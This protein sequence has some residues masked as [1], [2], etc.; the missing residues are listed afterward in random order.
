MIN[1]LA[2]RSIDNNTYY[3]LKDNGIFIRSIISGSISPSLITELV[4]DDRELSGN[5]IQGSEI[6]DFDT[7]KLDASFLSS[8]FKYFLYAA[9]REP[10]CQGKSDEELFEFYQF[11]VFNICCLIKRR[12]ID[13][14][15]FG[16]V[17]HRIVS[18]AAHVACLI[19]ST[20]PL[21]PYHNSLILESSDLKRRFAA[22]FICSEYSDIYRLPLKYLQKV[23]GCYTP[24][25]ILSL[26][27]KSNNYTKNSTSRGFLFRSLC[28]LMQLKR[29]FVSSN[30]SYSFF[31][32]LARFNSLF[33]ILYSFF[34]YER[35]CRYYIHHSIR[36]ITDRNYIVLVVNRKP[37]ATHS[38]LGGNYIDEARVLS[39]LLEASSR[40]D[41][42]ILLKEHPSTINSGFTL[43]T[44]LSTTNYMNY[45]MLSDRIVFA[46]PSF[47]DAH[48]REN[49]IAVACTTQSAGLEACFKK[50]KVIVFGYT[51]WSR[52]FNAHCFKSVSLLTEYLL[53][54]NPSDLPHTVAGRFPVPDLRSLEPCKFSETYS[55]MIKQSLDF[56]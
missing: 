28:L 24:E 48:L 19:T 53:S 32:F 8:Y 11:L 4:Y 49:C 44:C 38:P 12:N 54:S 23:S 51:W 56:L 39:V 31:P 52:V 16:T 14:I 55:K 43:G 3:S 17:P 2:C 34:Q 6:E 36:D 50:K 46:H 33:S 45:K 37:E 30:L 5:S 10:I 35:A 41:C 27:V 1:A 42:L 9:F 20:R 47:K 29:L 7:D 26:S 18:L 25:E 22:S 40:L 15:L 13:I 21:F